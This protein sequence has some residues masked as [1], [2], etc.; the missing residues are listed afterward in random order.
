MDLKSLSKIELIEQTANATDKAELRNILTQLGLT[1]SG[2]TG[3]DTLRAKLDEHI[4]ALPDAPENLPDLSTPPSFEDNGP[5][6][7]EIDAQTAKANEEAMAALLGL[8]AK[9]V[10]AAE[11]S[12]NRTE[13][14]DQELTHIDLNKL[15]DDKLIRRAMKLRHLRLLRVKITNLNPADAEVP[16]SIVTV[17]NPYLGKVSKFIPY[18]DESENGYHVPAILVQELKS[19][20]FPMRKLNKR[21]KFGVKTYKTVM[22]P[23]FSVEVLEDLSESERRQLALQQAASN[24]TDQ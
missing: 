19:R 4:A 1:F 18:G 23:K 17:L 9:S 21:S 24:Y 13:Y 11:V 8:A 22:A 2:N 6:D 15:T 7:D 20:K 5:S 3:E 16:G 12:P 10:P 14:S